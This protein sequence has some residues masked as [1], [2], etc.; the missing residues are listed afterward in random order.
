M[1]FGLLWQRIRML[2]KSQHKLCFYGSNG[3]FLRFFLEVC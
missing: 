1:E 2:W 3:Y